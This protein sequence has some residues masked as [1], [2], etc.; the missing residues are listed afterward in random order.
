VRLHDHCCEAFL[1]EN[2]KLV[3]WVNEQPLTTPV[4]CLGD[5]HDGIWNLFEDIATS[6]QRHEILDWFHLVENLNKVGGSQQRLAE[7][8]AFI[9]LLQIAL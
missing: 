8:E 2:K 5:G 9:C 7:V 1:Q 4:V 3:A 6:R